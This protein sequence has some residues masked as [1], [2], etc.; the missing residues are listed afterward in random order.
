MERGQRGRIGWGS[1]QS[2]LYNDLSGLENLL[3]YARLYRLND[4]IEVAT[5]WV[6]TVGLSGVA[7]QPVRTYSRGMRQRLS[8]A[9][10]LLNEPEVLL[11][12]EPFSGLDRQGIGQ[13]SQ[14]LAR[15]RDAGTLVILSTHVFDL[16]PKTVD[17]VL[18][19]KRGKVVHTGGLEDD[20]IG[21]L[22]DR[23]VD[24]AVD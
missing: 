4:S 22:Y 2:L 8:V 18:V 23:V 3:F 10:A 5:Q 21:A 12:D 24:G 16:P 15:A 6:E 11:L 13:V 19:L 7:H 14:V 1:H 9:R 17:R 20:D